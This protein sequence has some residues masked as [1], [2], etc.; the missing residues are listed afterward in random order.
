MELNK[1]EALT[2]WLPSSQALDEYHSWSPKSKSA[3]EVLS[4]DSELKQEE[5][6]G[7]A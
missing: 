3:A 1:G 2:T 6:H 4:T 7:L 5:V